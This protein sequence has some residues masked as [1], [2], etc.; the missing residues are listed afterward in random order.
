MA[1]NVTVGLPQTH[2]WWGHVKFTIWGNGVER[3]TAC[4]LG[5]IDS[6]DSGSPRV[7]VVAVDCD[8]GDTLGRSPARDVCNLI[9]FCHNMVGAQ[10]EDM[11]A[12]LTPGVTPHVELPAETRVMHS[13][14]WEHAYQNIRRR[15]APGDT[16]MFAL[17]G[18]GYQRRSAEKSGSVDDE[19]DGMDEFVM[20]SRR[21]MVLDDDLWSVVVE[22]ELKKPRD[23]RV[24]L[25][26]ITDTCHS[27]TMFDLPFNVELEHDG[28]ATPARRDMESILL[29]LRE[30]DALDAN[31]WAI[32]ASQDHELASC[33]IGTYGFG[34]AL[35]TALLDTQAIIPFLRGNPV[36]AAKTIQ[37]RLR[38]VGQQVALQRVDGLSNA[39]ATDTTRV[40]E[41]TKRGGGSYRRRRRKV[42]TRKAVPRPPVKN[43][44]LPRR[45]QRRR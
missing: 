13:H 14:E 25:R 19:L 5:D 9:R 40:T 33:D 1:Q 4:P 20:V 37:R 3:A 39:N 34:G 12:A 2:S 35:T 30:R 28:A 22:D 29:Y 18:H 8:P 31:I 10:G 7:R 43:S 23:E 44:L 36:D 11:V 16:L 38:G 45:R 17:T 32:G 26:L 41:S 15:C 24:R 21:Q 42:T 6:M 27:G